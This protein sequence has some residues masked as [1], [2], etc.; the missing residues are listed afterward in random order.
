MMVVIEAIVFILSAIVIFL[1]VKYIYLKASFEQRIK[2]WLQKEEARIRKDAIER[3]ARTLSG[4]TLE[5]LIPF[6]D[7]FPYD[8]HDLRWL[9]DPVDFIIF[10]GYSSEKSPKQI[11]FCEVKSGGGSLNKIQ[12]EIGNVFK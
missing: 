5:K 2:E 4:K 3:S 8:S 1:A 6:L 7:R 11:V 9:G 12:S 10:D